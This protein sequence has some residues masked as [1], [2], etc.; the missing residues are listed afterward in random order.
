MEDVVVVESVKPF[1]EACRALEAAIAGHRFGVLH[2]HD[3]RQTLTSK[4]IPFDRSVRIFDVC[5]PQRAKQALEE[6]ILVAAALPCAIAVVAEGDRTRF[7]FVRPTMMLHLFATPQLE[8]L[9]EDVERTVL[10][11]VESA[12][13]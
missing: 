4:G 2:V 7:V 3:V 9:A 8:P 1:D 5:N 6:N 12:A 13:R 11:I 10:A